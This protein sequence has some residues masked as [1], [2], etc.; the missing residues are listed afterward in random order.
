ML[1]RH[2]RCIWFLYFAVLCSTSCQSPFRASPSAVLR[3]IFAACGNRDYPSVNAMTDEGIKTLL[4]AAP[5]KEAT[6]ENGV[7]TLLQKHISA[8]V[9]R[10]DVTEEVIHG[11]K[12]IVTYNAWAGTN[13]S[14]D[15]S[16][17]FLLQ[18][19]SW[20]VTMVSRYGGWEAFIPKK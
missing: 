2:G 9:S 1:Y 11:D 12:A 16:T 19:G 3:N 4:A 10:I 13:L 15:R 8:P 20:K 18:N 14:S 17:G 7:C 6:G 5:F